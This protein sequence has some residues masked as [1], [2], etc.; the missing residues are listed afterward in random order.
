MWR[1]Q[2]LTI[3]ARVRRGNAGLPRARLCLR[4]KPRAIKEDLMPNEEDDESG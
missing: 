3:L 1:R 2:I 4:F